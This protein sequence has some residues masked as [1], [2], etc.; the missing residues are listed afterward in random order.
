MTEE[1]NYCSL[2]LE[3][4]EKEEEGKHNS[5]AVVHTIRKKN[6]VV[7][8]CYGCCVKTNRCTYCNEYAGVNP[9]H[10]AK[11][12]LRYHKDTSIC[13]DECL[14]KL[15]Q[16]GKNDFGKIQGT[17]GKMTYTI[18]PKESLSHMNEYAKRLCKT[19]MLK[20]IELRRIEKELTKTKE[21]LKVT[22]YKF[23][24]KMDL[25]KTELE[26][27]DKVESLAISLEKKLRQCTCNGN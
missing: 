4:F 1:P 22:E 21:K 12:D 17:I 5:K 2:C 14:Q 8:L 3:K 25:R 15:D 7:Y 18:D 16:Y 24:V 23:K 13:C 20:D 9:V 27:K 11:D 6:G 10:M 19:L 26:L